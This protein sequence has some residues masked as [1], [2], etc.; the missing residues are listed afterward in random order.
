MGS[1]EKCVRVEKAA[2]LLRPR[3]KSCESLRLFFV[4]IIIIY[5]LQI[6]VLGCYFFTLLFCGPRHTIL[7]T[8]FTS[9]RSF[10]YKTLVSELQTA[11]KKASN[12]HRSDPV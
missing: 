5:T 12:C 11:L 8:L 6:H 3:R 10:L 7:N 9:Y 1:D 4:S 2:R